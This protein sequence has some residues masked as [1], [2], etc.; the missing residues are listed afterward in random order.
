MGS[1]KENINQDV[2][3]EEKNLFFNI[4]EKRHNLLELKKYQSMKNYFS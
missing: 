4:K 3:C 2:L 1:N